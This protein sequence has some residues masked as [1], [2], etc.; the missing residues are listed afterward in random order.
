ML[1]SLASSPF[2]KIN[3]PVRRK[4]QPHRGGLSPSVEQFDGQISYLVYHI[5]Y[6]DSHNDIDD[7]SY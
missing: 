1:I 7:D 5:L 6:N 4:R 2:S 3:S